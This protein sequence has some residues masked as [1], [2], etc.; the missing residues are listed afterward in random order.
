M[1][2]GEWGRR[3]FIQRW[4]TFAP[5]VL[6]PGVRSQESGA[7]DVDDERCEFSSHAASLKNRTGLRMTGKD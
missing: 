5:G 3:I 1:G 2:S 7:S 4:S 6:W